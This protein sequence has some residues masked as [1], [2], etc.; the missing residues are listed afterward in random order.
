[1]HLGLETAEKGAFPIGR[2]LSR[3][4]VRADLELHEA[5][6][7]GLS[8]IDQVTPVRSGCLKVRTCRNSTLAYVSP[9][10]QQAP[11]NRTLAWINPL[12]ISG[13]PFTHGRESGVAAS[14]S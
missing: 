7:T 3:H 2:F 5:H 4:R 8:G 10:G 1:M 13:H 11:T 6:R 14:P 9:S 12:P